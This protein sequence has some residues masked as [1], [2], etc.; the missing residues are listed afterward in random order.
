MSMNFRLALD[1]LT[2][3]RAILLVVATFGLGCSPGDKNCIPDSG[4]GQGPVAAC[5]PDCQGCCRDGRCI[6][7]GSPEA[8]GSGGAACQTCSGA[9]QCNPQRVC[10]APSCSGC[11]TENG[12]CVTGTTDG[13]CGKDGLTCQVCP[14]DKVCIQ[15][16]CTTCG[17]SNC[18]GCC[19]GNVCIAFEDQQASACG[20]G[21]AAC[22]ACPS[23]SSCQDGSCVVKPACI[24]CRA[25]ECCDMSGSSPRCVS[26]S[27]ATCGR[28]TDVCTACAAPE[29]CGINEARC[30]TPGDAPF[31]STCDSDKQCAAVGATGMV[32][33]A[34]FFPGGFCT[35]LCNGPNQCGPEGTCSRSG[36]TGFCMKNCAT[37]GSTAECGHPALV[38]DSFGTSQGVCTLACSSDAYCKSG[39]NQNLRCNPDSRCCGAAHFACCASGT[40]CAGQNA[41]GTGPSTCN[42]QG[43]CT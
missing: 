32:Y 15:G 16:E 9:Q 23:S 18:D 6:A 14:A 1:P 22:S 40:P 36:T 24:G 37:P 17:A 41:E 25:G 31:G 39:G 8:C 2:L 7:G 10:Q 4:C 26:I 27:N 21:G 35:D 38:C 19:D 3:R 33:C 34:S 29:V 30:V 13:A 5:G 12:A 43:Y 42:E 11:V 28:P 20:K